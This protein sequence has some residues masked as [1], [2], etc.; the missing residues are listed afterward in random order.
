MFS[1]SANRMLSRGSGFQFRSLC[2]KIEPAHSLALSQKSDQELNLLIANCSR[3]L[4]ERK[5]GVEKKAF[6]ALLEHAVIYG[7]SREEQ[8]LA[9]EAI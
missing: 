1:L 8:Q 9:L 7:K 2:Q 6:K 4:S 5:A 3:E